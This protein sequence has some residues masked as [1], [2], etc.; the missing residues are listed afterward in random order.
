MVPGTDLRFDGPAE[1]AEAL[2]K[3]PRFARCLTRK[4]LTYALGRGMEAAD[5]P[6]L[7]HLS[8]AIR[9]GRLPLPGS[10]RDHRHQ[11]ADDH[12]GRARA[13]HEH[14]EKLAAV[15]DGPVLRGLGASHGAALAG[16]DGR[17][18]GP[19]RRRPKPLRFLTVFAPHG[20]HMPAWTPK[21]DGRRLR[22]TPILQPLGPLRAAVQRDLRPGQL[23]GQHHHQGVRRLARP[24]HRRA[25]HPVAAAV[26]R[27][28]GHPERHLDRPGDRQ[29]AQGA[30][31]LPSLEVGVSSGSATGNC[32]DGYSCAYLHN[33]SWCGPTTFMPKEISPRALLNR[34][35][36]GGGVPGR[37]LTDRSRRP[38]PR[39]PPPAD[40]DLIYRKS[41]LDVVRG[42]ATRLHGRLGR[43]DRAKLDEYLTS[44]GELQRRIV[45]FEKP[46]RAPAPPRRPP[47]AAPRAPRPPRAHPA[48]TSST[49]SCCR[50]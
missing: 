3:D 45:D 9:G 46:A 4:L 42:D 19:G 13:S 20:I 21:H 25:A 24:R 16:G 1:L 29:P 7:D 33:I 38:G 15:A 26:H 8:G 47:P 5:A 14:H 34:L 23:P 27:Q 10:G 18:A 6:A 41:V 11:P 35:F 49:S 50:T 31:R 28:Q 37:P 30:T 43:R 32:E 48:A 40:K 36:S 22:L 2:Q 17:P 39:P 44:V 12:A